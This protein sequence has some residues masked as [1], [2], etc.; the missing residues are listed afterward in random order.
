M[1]ILRFTA[2]SWILSQALGLAMEWKRSNEHF[3]NK[4][5][6]CLTMP[7]MPLFDFKLEKFKSKKR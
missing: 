7:A 4:L 2:V 1:I 3:Q 5:P 6:E